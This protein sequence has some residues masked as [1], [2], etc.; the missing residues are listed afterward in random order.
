MLLAIAV[1]RSKIQVQVHVRP[2]GRW[3]RKTQILE[4]GLGAPEIWR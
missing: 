2:T 1:A 3:R 4:V